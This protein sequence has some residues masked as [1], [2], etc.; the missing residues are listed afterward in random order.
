MKNEEMV[1]WIAEKYE[2]IEEMHERINHDEL[3]AEA[4]LSMFERK[5]LEGCECLLPLLI[6]ES[7]D[8]PTSMV[9]KKLFLELCAGEAERNGMEAFVQRVCEDLARAKEQYEE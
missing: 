4:I 2:T 1:R 8:I 5:M 6:C 7:V 3:N 9:R